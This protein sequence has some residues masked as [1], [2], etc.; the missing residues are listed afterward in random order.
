MLFSL[1]NGRNRARRGFTLVELLVV[2]AIIGILVGLLLPA[3]QAA[4]EAAR[5]MS[6]QNNLHQLGLAAHNFESTYKKFPPGQIGPV[7]AS[8]ANPWDPGQV[9]GYYTGIGH[10]G[11]MLPNLE[12]TAGYTPIQQWRTLNVDAFDYPNPLPSAVP[13]SQQYWFWDDNPEIYNA[14][15]TK[16]S[17]FLCPSD[18]AEG[19]I[20]N[21]GAGTTGVLFAPHRN[22]TG[23]STWLATDIP[24]DPVGIRMGLTNYLGSMGRLPGNGAEWAAAAGNPAFGP[25]IDN[26]KGIFRYKSKT[27]M[28]HISDGTSQTFMFGE[29]TGGWVEPLKPAQRRFSFSWTNVGM[30]SHWHGTN[31]SGSITY[32]QR[33][34]QWWRFSSMHP[35][36]TVQFAYAD[37]SVRAVNLSIQGRIMYSMSGMADADVLNEM[38]E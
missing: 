2:I 38:P 26:Y 23:L 15:Y 30:Y 27:R 13:V 14:I 12:Q 22:G 9:F 20:K 36:D 25:L 7:D 24:P 16:Y 34:K 18:N 10:L 3:V 21:N 37:A 11:Y 17:V 8:E 33:E 32:N 4:R 19:Y 29:V 6:C 5:R 28:G 35:G 31:L 1:S